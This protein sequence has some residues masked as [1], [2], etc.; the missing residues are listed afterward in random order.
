MD[1]NP[2]SLNAGC[3][4]PAFSPYVSR[5]GLARTGGLLGLMELGFLKIDAYTMDLCQLVE[6]W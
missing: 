3:A 5:G 6:P 2:R 4:C 1:Q